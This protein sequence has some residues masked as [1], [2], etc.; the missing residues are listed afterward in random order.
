MTRLVVDEPAHCSLVL[1]IEAKVQLQRDVCGRE[2][3]E[4]G[5]SEVVVAHARIDKELTRFASSSATSR[6]V[7]R[8]WT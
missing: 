8:P 4:R 7:P 2:R 1:R 3:L 6:G 5:S